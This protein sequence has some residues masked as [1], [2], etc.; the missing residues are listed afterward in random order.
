MEL[1]RAGG[2]LVVDTAFPRMKGGEMPKDLW[3]CFITMESGMEPGCT[4]LSATLRDKKST[5]D[6][7]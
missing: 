4:T 6:H 5:S 7:Q 1:G 3:G 2:R